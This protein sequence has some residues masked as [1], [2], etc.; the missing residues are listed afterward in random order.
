M[1]NIL[2]SLNKTIVKM[3]PA[4]TVLFS[5]CKI[6]DTFTSKKLNIIP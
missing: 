2:Q 5:D 1:S 3:I 4:T 6:L